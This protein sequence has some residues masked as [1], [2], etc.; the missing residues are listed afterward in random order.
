VRRER[1]EERKAEAQGLGAEGELGGGA[2]PLLFP[3]PHVHGIG[4]GGMRP[5]SASSFVISLVRILSSWERPGRRAIG[6]LATSRHRA[7]SGRETRTKC[8]LPQSR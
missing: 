6:E 1:E 7:D 5:G 3:P 4:R 2:E 8:M